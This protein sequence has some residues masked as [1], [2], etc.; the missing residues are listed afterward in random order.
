MLLPVLGSKGSLVAVALSYLL[1]TPSLSLGVWTPAA[2]PLMLVWLLPSRTDPL[3]ALPEEVVAYREGVL[4]SVATVQTAPGSLELR[5]NGHFYMGGTSGAFGERRQGHLLLLL[6]PEPRRA[7]FLGLG[8]GIT[9]GAAAVH[10][11]LRAEAVEL[12]PEVVEMLPFFREY[13]GNLLQRGQLEV[14]IADACPRA[15][16]NERSGGVAGGLVQAARPIAGSVLSPGRKCPG[17]RSGA[18]RNLCRRR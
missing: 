11:G 3:K 14:R 13:N 15:G 9:F 7:L 18:I 6:H 5:V 8:T 4:A 10:P 2:L 12:V 17:R 16:R 1:L